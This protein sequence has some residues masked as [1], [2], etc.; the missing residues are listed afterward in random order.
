[1]S[2][3]YPIPEAKYLTQEMIDNFVSYSHELVQTKK[4]DYPTLDPH[5][6]TDVYHVV[7]T[8]KGLFKTRTLSKTFTFKR[9]Y[10]QYR[11]EKHRL[12]DE[13]KPTTAAEMFGKQLTKLATDDGIYNILDELEKEYAED[14]AG[15]YFSAGILFAI[16]KFKE[17]LGEK[18]SNN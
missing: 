1:M 10:R 11:N 8:K 15:D 16:S 17:S 3:Y 13:W 4:S 18:V 5:E 7:Y 6:Y 2:K 9:L 12:I 14:S